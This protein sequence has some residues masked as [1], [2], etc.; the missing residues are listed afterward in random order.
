MTE[1]ATVPPQ[2]GDAPTSALDYFARHPLVGLI[3]TI[4]GIVGVVVTLIVFFISQRSREICYM[5]SASPTTIVRA[6]QSSDLRVH[7]KDKELTSDVSSIQIVIWNNGKESV[8]GANI[9]S[10]VSL[11][12]LPRSAILE[13]RVKKVTRSLVGFEIFNANASSGILGLSWNILESGDGALLEV[14]YTGTSEKVAIDGAI[15]DMPA[16]RQVFFGNDVRFTIREVV[17]M[18]LFGLAAG[19]LAAMKQYRSKSAALNITAARINV[20]M[21]F[22]MTSA[23]ISGLLAVGLLVFAA[24]TLHPPFSFRAL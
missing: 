3:G 4:A 16:V 1:D 2:P 24:L 6:G 7:Y 10:A 18:S 12:L 23:C 11:Q 9:L 20:A 22:L 5:V 8:K 17:F 14:I 19:V 15:E 13:A 21:A